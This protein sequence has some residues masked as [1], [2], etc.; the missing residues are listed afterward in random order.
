[1]FTKAKIVLIRFIVLPSATMIQHKMMYAI[2]LVFLIVQ[3]ELG[4]T[5]V[6]SEITSLSQH[7]C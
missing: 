6:L 5:A 3:S 4:K 7:F 1:M 2:L